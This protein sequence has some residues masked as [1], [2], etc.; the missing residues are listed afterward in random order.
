MSL[1]SKFT[2]LFFPN[3]CCGCE[4]HAVTGKDYFCLACSYDCPTTNLHRE[5]ENECLERLAGRIPLYHGSSMFRFT[6]EGKVQHMIHL[7]KYRGHRQ[8]A[9]RLGEAY[10][11]KMHESLFPSD[12]ILLP[13]PL[14]PK[15]QQKRGYNQSHH[16]AV[17]IAA[18]SGWQIGDNILKRSRNT[19]TQT[20]MSR[21]DRL[22]N[23]DGAFELVMPSKIDGRHVV[24][25]DD[26]LTTGA[27]IEACAKE[28]IGRCSSLSFI[29]I[30]LAV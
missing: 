17:G 20:A 10:G 22:A 19:S 1:L 27:T 5:P 21:E 18:S 23:L 16:F 6:P 4:Q 29:T 12:P 24:L 28:L 14:H 2:H 9:E 15:K 30:G 3:L 7:I 11:A 26:I 25:V 13:V 8:A